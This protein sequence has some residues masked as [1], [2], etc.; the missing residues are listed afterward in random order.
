MVNAWFDLLVSA[1]RRGA[2]V[3]LLAAALCLAVPA[4]LRAVEGGPF[5]RIGTGG[6]AG[7]EFVVG[8]ALAAVLQ[9]AFGAEDPEDPEDPED[10]EDCGLTDCS[11]APRL[12]AAQLSA[13]ALANL[14]G[15]ARG[16]GLPSLPITITFPWRGPLGLRVALPV[17]YHIYFGEPL[18][19]SG[20]PSEEDAVVQRKVDA[21]RRSIAELFK[22]GRSERRGIFR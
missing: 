12:V 7:S 2:P 6:E 20:D 1:L 13:G 8:Q 3:A 10:S 14:R 18:H 15:L 17:K 9:Q 11:A 21:V 5:L 22:R 16:V 4:A 19:F